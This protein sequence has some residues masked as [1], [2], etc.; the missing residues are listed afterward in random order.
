MGEE[1]AAHWERVQGIRKSLVCILRVPDLN[2]AVL[3]RMNYDNNS[4]MRL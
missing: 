2:K 3:W 1:T 4:C